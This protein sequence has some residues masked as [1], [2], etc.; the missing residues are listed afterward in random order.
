MSSNL[1]S[2]APQRPRPMPMNRLCIK[3]IIIVSADQPLIVHKGGHT[4]KK[5]L[6]ICNEVFGD[7]RSLPPHSI[8]GKV[9]K[10][11]VDTRL[12][13]K[14]TVA[15]QVGAILSFQLICLPQ[16]FQITLVTKIGKWKATMIQLLSGRQDT[17]LK[18]N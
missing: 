8:V 2:A 1:Q 16:T 9:C 12:A 10:V 3:S 5:Y 15:T 17:M 4:H 14:T 11:Q 7:P 18:T 6:R 13:G